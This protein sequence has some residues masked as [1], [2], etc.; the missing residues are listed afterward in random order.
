MVKEDDVP[1][2]T[3]RAAV[4][5]AQLSAWEHLQLHFFLNHAVD[6]N[7]SGQ[8]LLD[9]LSNLSQDDSREDFLRSMIHDL[10]SLAEKCMFWGPRV[11]S[12]MLTTW[13]VSRST[14]ISSGT[15]AALRERQNNICYISG[16]SQDLRAIHIIS[17]SVLND[18][19]L[20]PGVGSPSLKITIFRTHL[21][22]IYRPDYAKSWRHP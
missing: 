10:R 1:F 18:D 3:A 13:K 15:I 12:Y 19:D 22:I 14:L 2:W 6:R 21:I 8:F 4:Y 11:F 7:M 5:S 20:Q 16:S 17:P 9:K